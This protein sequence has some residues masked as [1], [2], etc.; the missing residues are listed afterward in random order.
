[1]NYDIKLV[2]KIGSMALIR[3]VEH[4]ID[5]NVFSRIGSEFHP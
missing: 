4:D 1:M 2:G 3:E 5:Y